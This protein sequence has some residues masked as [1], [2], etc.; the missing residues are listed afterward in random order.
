MKWID[1][2]QPGKSMVDTLDRRV[3]FVIGIIGVFIDADT[4]I[5]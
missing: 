5:G 3:I 1:T 2:K 4:H